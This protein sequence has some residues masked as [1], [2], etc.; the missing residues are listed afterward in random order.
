MTCRIR[1]VPVCWLLV[2]SSWAADTPV[3]KPPAG[4][5]GEAR[6]RL[7][8]GNYAEAR[9]KYESAAKDE[10]TAVAATVGL[11]RAW[12]AEGDHDRGEQVLT[13]LLDAGT[14]HADLL[15]ERSDV[16]FLRG[17]WD[18]AEADAK[19]AIRLKDEQ[20]TAR[21]TIARLH[22]DR[23]Q[24][25]DADRT[26][27]WFV[28]T[29]TARSNADNDIVDPDELLL[30]AQAAAENARWHRLTKQF[31]FILNEVIKDALKADKSLAAAEAFAGML[32]LEKYNRPDAID[33]FDKALEI[34]PKCVDAIV[35]KGLASML[36]FEI[37]DADKA[38]D[39]ALRVNPNSVAALLLK[40]DVLLAAGDFAATEKRLLAARSV[41]PRDS[42]VLG[43][44]AACHTLRGQTDLAEKAIAEAESYDA[45]PADFYHEFANV[46]DDRK[47]YPVAEKYY[48]KA[49]G[50]RPLQPQAPLALGML[51]M[52]LGK[53]TDARTIL[54]KAYESDPFNVRAR[55][56][57]EVLKHLD[58]YQTITTPHY[59][60]KYD[61]K[62][63]ALLASFVAEYLEETHAELKR[64]F[65]GEPPGRTLVQLFNSHEMFSGRIV[66]LPD[67]HTI[68][69]CTGP[70]FAMASPKAKG[71]KRPFNW[72]RV[73]RHELTHVF[74]LTATDYQCPHWLTEGLAVRNEE[75][76]RPPGWTQALRQRYRAN[77]LF[78][79]DTIMFGFVRPRNPQE[80][81]LAYCQSHLYV[82]YVVKT[83]GE[84]VIAKLLAR[85][86][87]GDDTP[88][89]FRKACGLP[90]AEFEAGYKAYVAEVLKPYLTDDREPEKPLTFDEL[91]AAYDE[92]PDN[93]DVAARYAEQL[94]KRGKPGDARK[95]VD[96]V[97]KAKPGHP[98]GTLV[99]ARLLMRAGE[100]DV[101]R[102]LVDDAVKANSNDTRLL[103]AAALMFLESKDLDRAA[104]LLE[105][106]RKL[107]P[108]DADWT[109]SLVRLYSET[110]Q[111]TNLLDV[112][113]EVVAGDPDELV[114]RMKLAR[115]ALKGKKFDVA[116]KFAREAIQI[117]V[118]NPDV[119][120]LY[121][122]ILSAAGKTE[123][124]DAMKKR[125]GK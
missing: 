79:L 114:G 109:G 53:E 106:G 13:A 57:I 14:N 11:S 15:A 119:Q 73:V 111:A 80:W 5:L 2:T 87:A 125:F 95:I 58:G 6:E 19:A 91:K 97:L 34:N 94:A 61:A 24:L 82:E 23:G 12:R 103:Y 27:R 121:V 60:L 62:T 122:E 35:G 28:K 49:A 33:A 78:T 64:Q 3:W 48:L 83:Y 56:T 37:Q 52:R 123:L 16:R 89:A 81:S 10:K 98:T 31:S 50:L 116:E 42:R 115:E 30:V 8:R 47:R 7:N 1:F 25:D 65:G 104:E 40:A 17:Q 105:R 20:F 88:T 26:M 90:V 86:Q 113:R 66:G 67:L 74:N 38:A 93:H 112:L 124:A 43:K 101:A 21:W 55:N 46:L 100:D 18:A 72:G 85:Y 75:M 59:T 102:L 99:K 36:K 118:T 39:E 117:D 84:G 108:L 41:S 9:A 120:S 92:D 63:D 69:A 68:G 32:L 45:K 44:L 107:A 71:V 22:R 54:A 4:L 70:L 96:G 77:D 110:D 29:Y 51:A 76:A